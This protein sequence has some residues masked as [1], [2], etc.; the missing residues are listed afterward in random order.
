MPSRHSWA[1]RLLAEP[2]IKVCGV[3]DRAVLRAAIEAGATAIGFNFVSGSRRAL[4][5]QKGRTLIQCMKEV[6]H[7]PPTVVGVF[8]DAPLDDLIGLRRLLGLEVL[9]LHGHELPEQVARLQPAYKALRVGCLKDVDTV[10]AYPGE[11]VLIDAQVG[12]Q[13][14][15]TGQRIPMDLVRRATQLRRAIVAGGLN[16]HNVGRLIAECRPAGVDTASGAE[17]DAGNPCADAARRFV[18]AARDAFAH[19][20]AEEPRV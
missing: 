7:R 9:Q 5:K 19:L 11:L 16:E 6:H 12:R 10:A 3:R 15:G 17:D 13:L 20:S 1:N 2:V 4:D 18:Q 14:G 8:A